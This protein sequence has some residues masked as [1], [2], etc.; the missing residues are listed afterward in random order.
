MLIHRHESHFNFPGA[1][2][3]KAS[4]KSPSSPAGSCRLTQMRGVSVSFTI[5][6]VLA[7]PLIGAG[8]RE[9]WRAGVG[10]SGEERA[11][12]WSQ[13]CTKRFTYLHFQQFCEVHF[14][15]QDET[16]SSRLS[17]LET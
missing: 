3:S 6:G 2:K 5:T 7:L 15:T 14:I 13:H 11:G 12:R 8:E 9:S 16:V 17:N 4:S 1:A 10:T